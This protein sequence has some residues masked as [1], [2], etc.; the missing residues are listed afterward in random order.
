MTVHNKELVGLWVTPDADD[1]AEQRVVRRSG[2]QRPSGPGLADAGGLE[3]KPHR[4]RADVSHRGLPDLGVAGHHVAPL[5]RRHGAQLVGHRAAGF[6]DRRVDSVDGGAEL[7]LGFGNGRSWV[8][9]G[10]LGLDFGLL[11]QR[12]P[13]AHLLVLLGNLSSAG[14]SL[15]GGWRWALRGCLGGRCRCCC[16]VDGL[17]SSWGFRCGCC[18]RGSTCWWL[19]RTVGHAGLMHPANRP[20]CVPQAVNH[21]CGRWPQNHESLHRVLPT[22]IG[23]RVARLAQYQVVSCVPQG[24]RQRVDPFGGTVGNA[25]GFAGVERRIVHDG[26]SRGPLKN[27]LG[28]LA[29][30]PSQNSGGPRCALGK[31]SG[32]LGG[33]SDR[34][35]CFSNCCCPRSSHGQAA[36]AFQASGR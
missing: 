7:G 22:G 33:L 30:T 34:G 19:R 12:L 24:I 3:L 31:G 10:P 26:A 20:G 8:S 16:D 29:G 21:A 14:W 11:P 27:Q 23:R 9:K 1:L 13:W 5:N 36:S 4:V 18:G 32:G 28:G 35:R 15:G 17:R 2:L 6:G 25:P